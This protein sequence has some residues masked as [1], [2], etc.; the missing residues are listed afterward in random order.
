MDFFAQ[1]HLK[2]IVYRI[3]KNFHDRQ[4]INFIPKI[5]IK[6]LPFSYTFIHET[7]Q[8]K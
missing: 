2:K 7:T 8:N 4:F 6:Y 1:I 3:S 5:G